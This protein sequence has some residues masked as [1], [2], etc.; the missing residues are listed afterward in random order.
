MV[1]Y[2]LLLFIIINSLFGQSILVPISNKVIDWKEK[3]TRDDVI[4]IEANKKYSCKKYID[5]MLLK[6]KQYRAKHYI[7][8]NKPICLKDVYLNQTKKIKFNF[9]SLEIEKEGEL[10]KQTDEYI[11]IRNSEGV[12]E[13]IYKD[14]SVK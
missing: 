8:K 7:H 2:I 13:K 3:I 11:K 10:L 5:M 14:G 12:I 6:Q 4:L 9:G 1:K